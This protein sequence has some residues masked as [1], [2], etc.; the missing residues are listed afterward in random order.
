MALKPEELQNN[1]SMN[2]S[3]S[4]N[5]AIPGLNFA[6]SSERSGCEGKQYN[7]LKT[8]IVSLK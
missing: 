7:N 5:A 2:R 3:P 6:N 8:K 1:Y 4:L